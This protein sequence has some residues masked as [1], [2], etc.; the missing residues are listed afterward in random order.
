MPQ[1]IEVSAMGFRQRIIA[2]AQESRGCREL[3]LWRYLLYRGLPATSFPCYL[4]PVRLPLMRYRPLGI[5]PFIAG[6]GREHRAAATYRTLIAHRSPHLFQLPSCTTTAA[7]IENPI[8][9]STPPLMVARP[10]HSI[11]PIEGF[12][13]CNSI[14]IY[15]IR[16]ARGKQMKVE[17]SG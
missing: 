15:H 1:S 17:A 12:V 8:I 13:K 7:G 6:G 14:I 16:S 10:T 11:S 4:A 2:S 5:S 3:S 9:H